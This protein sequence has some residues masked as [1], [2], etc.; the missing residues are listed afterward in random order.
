MKESRKQQK[1]HLNKQCKS[2]T[3][4]RGRLISI[5][6]SKNNHHPLGMAGVTCGANDYI[7]RLAVAIKMRKCFYLLSRH[8][9][10]RYGDVDLN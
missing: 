5:I 8:Q 2:H 4:I 10:T 9:L 1:G 3:H 6:K 7:R